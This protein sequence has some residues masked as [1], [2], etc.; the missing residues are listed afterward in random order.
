M[1]FGNELR[2][3]SLFNV[4]SRSSAASPLY[5]V[6]LWDASLSGGRGGIFEEVASHSCHGPAKLLEERHVV[7]AH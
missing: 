2:Y 7:S 4:L 5:P 3:S 6:S 1:V